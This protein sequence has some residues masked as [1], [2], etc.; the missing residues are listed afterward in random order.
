MKCLFSNR[1]QFPQ[2]FCFSSVLSMAFIKYKI[3]HIWENSLG[4]AARKEKDRQKERR[5]GRER[6]RGERETGE[7]KREK[8]TEKE[9]EK[10]RERE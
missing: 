5:E 6:Q 3:L 2:K 8:E 4:K 7:V 1:Y 9:T 10:E